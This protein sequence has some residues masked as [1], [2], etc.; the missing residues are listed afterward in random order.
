MDATAVYENLGDLV[1][2]GVEASNDWIVYSRENQIV[3]NWSIDIGSWHPPGFLSCSLKV[4]RVNDSSTAVS[5]QD[6]VGA[7]RFTL[8]ISEN[9]SYLQNGNLSVPLSNLDMNNQD[10]VTLVCGLKGFVRNK[11]LPVQKSGIDSE[12]YTNF[13]FLQE[14]R[15]VIGVEKDNQTT[16]DFSYYVDRAEKWIPCQWEYIR[17]Y[18]ETGMTNKPFGNLTVFIGGT[19]IPVGSGSQTN[20]DWYTAE[21]NVYQSERFKTKIDGVAIENSETTWIKEEDRNACPGTLYMNFTVEGY[22]QLFGRSPFIVRTTMTTQTDRRFGGAIGFYGGLK[23]YVE[24][25]AIGGG[26]WFDETDDNPLTLDATFHAGIFS[27]K[28]KEDAFTLTIE[29]KNTTNTSSIPVFWNWKQDVAY[30]VSGTYDVNITSNNDVVKANITDIVEQ[31]TNEIVYTHAAN[32]GKYK[33]DLFC[34]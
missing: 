11:Q 20:N 2:G 34:G 8:N 1:E 24:R 3:A 33:V 10:N 30:H 25:T 29:E 7:D 15:A 14:D 32:R 18:K 16:E 6:M 9:T 23:E 19:P 12:D 31:G 13:S 28:R 22:A 5:E 26:K 17:G 21:M 27:K 4:Y